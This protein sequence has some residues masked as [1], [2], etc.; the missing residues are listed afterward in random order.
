MKIEY[1]SNF[2]SLC[3]DYVILN[4]SK[5]IVVACCEGACLRGE[6]ARKATNLFCHSLLPN[7]TVRLCLGS[8][9]TKKGRTTQVGRKYKENTCIRRMSR[10]LRIKI[11]KWAFF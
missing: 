1:T 7:R 11:D 2:C 3:E 10:G 5:P 4:D 8:A 6:I 9:L